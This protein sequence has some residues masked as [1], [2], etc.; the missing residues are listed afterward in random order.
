MRGAQDA[1]ARA[2]DRLYME[3]ASALAQAHLPLEE[4]WDQMLERLLQDSDGALY[5]ISYINCFGFDPTSANDRAEEFLAVAKLFFHTKPHLSDSQ[6]LLLWDYI[7]SMVFYY[8]EKFLHYMAYN[9]ENRA[10]VRQLL[11]SGMDRFGQ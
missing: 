4:I 5:Y 10:M 9:Q 6:Y 3:Q 7:T 1:A 11:F 2:F 8:M